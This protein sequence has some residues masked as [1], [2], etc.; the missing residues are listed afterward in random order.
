MDDEADTIRI[1]RSKDEL[2][3]TA[4]IELLPGRYQGRSWNDGSLF[5]KEEVFGYLAP[6]IEKYE[7]AFD[8]ESF[9]GI[10]A[11]KWT[12]IITGLEK[13]SDELGRAQAFSELIIRPGFLFVGTEARFKEHF[14][15]RKRELRELIQ[16]L[17]EW[18]KAQLKN[19][20]WISVL[21]I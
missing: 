20:E 1:L 18:L 17:V 13:L 12:G 10:S 4:Y 2:E 21:G 19:H 6:I 15:D 16:E 8:L 5:F 7:P 11:E 14:H 9:T 3:G